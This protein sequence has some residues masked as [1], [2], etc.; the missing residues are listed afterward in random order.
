MNLGSMVIFSRENLPRIKRETCVKNLDDKQ[1]K[2]THWVSLFIDI[3]IAVCF[4]SFGI[5]HI[6]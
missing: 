3:S 2:G 1:S 5:E 4:D 6:P